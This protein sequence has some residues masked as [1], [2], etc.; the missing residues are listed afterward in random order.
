MVCF[1]D[2][3]KNM[4]LLSWQQYVRGSM[5][6]KREWNQETEELG[7]STGF[8]STKLCNLKLI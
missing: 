1:S 2:Y 7:S 5:I 4:V 6:K 3:V 8:A